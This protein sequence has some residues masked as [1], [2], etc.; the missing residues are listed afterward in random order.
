MKNVNDLFIRLQ[1]SPQG[2]LTVPY[3]IKPRFLIKKLK[4]K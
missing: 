3:T 1:K 2:L 4:E